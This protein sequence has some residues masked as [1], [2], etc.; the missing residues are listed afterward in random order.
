MLDVAVSPLGVATTL[1]LQ[2]PL[3]AKNP[4]ANPILWL[5][6]NATEGQSKLKVPPLLTTCEYLH[7][8]AAY[9]RVYLKLG[10][11]GRNLEAETLD[12]LLA[13]LLAFTEKKITYKSEQTVH[14]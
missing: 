6:R 12:C 2:I 10:Q 11:G 14:L 4:T 1:F 3:T 7:Q 5:E 13:C 9:R 8:T